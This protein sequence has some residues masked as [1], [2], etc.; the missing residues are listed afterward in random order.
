MHEFTS[1]RDYASGEPIHYW[2][3]TTGFEVDFILG[4]HTAIEVKAKENVSAQDLKSLRVLAEKKKLSRYL[5][6]SLEPRP[7]KV[8]GV[9]ILPLQKFLETL[10]QGTFS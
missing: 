8:E 7:R 10:W 3:S 1:Y 5:C 4:D 9:E 2:R 6:A